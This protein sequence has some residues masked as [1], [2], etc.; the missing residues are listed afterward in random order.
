MEAFL[1]VVSECSRE[2]ARR[3]LEAADYNVERAVNFYFINQERGKAYASTSK[4]R[5]VVGEDEG[6]RVEGEDE[7]VRVEGVVGVEKKGEAKLTADPDLVL[8]P[9]KELSGESERLVSQLE[10]CP[11]E[12]TFLPSASWSRILSSCRAEGQSFTDP[13]FPPAAQSID[14]R[15]VHRNFG[16]N[17]KLLCL[18]KREAKL[19]KVAKDGKNQGKFFYACEL[20]KCKY[21][22]WSGRALQHTSQAVNLSWKRFDDPC[23]IPVAKGGFKPSDVLQGAVGDCWFLSGLAVIAERKDLV[24]RIFPVTQRN[25]EG[26]YECKFYID[27]QWESVVVDNVLPVDEERKPAFA[28]LSK[29]KSELWVPLLEKAYAKVHKSYDAISGGFVSEAMFDLTSYP[30]EVILVMDEA[31]ESEVTWA[32]LLSFASLKFPMGCSTQWDPT[33]QGVG[34]APCHAYSILEVIELSGVTVGQQLKIDD[35]FGGGKEREKAKKEEQGSLLRLLRIRNPHGQREWL[36]DWSDKSD[37]WTSTLHA[38]L[39]RTEK[40]D[41]TFWMSYQDFLCR[42]ALIEVCHAHRDFYNVTKRLRLGTPNSW[43]CAQF[44]VDLVEATWAYIMVLQKS[45]RGRLDNYWYTDVSIAIFRLDGQGGVVALEKVLFGG[46]NKTVFSELMMPQGQYLLN[47]FSMRKGVEADV[48]LRIFS[49][50][51]AVLTELGHGRDKLPPV[52]HHCM[53]QC[54]MNRACSSDMRGGVGGISKIAQHVVSP[55]LLLLVFCCSNTAVF[56]LACSSSE[57]RYS[58]LK[59]E[60]EAE[61]TRIKVD[62]A[63]AMIPPNA[64]KILAVLTPKKLGSH[65]FSYL[66]EE[67]GPTD[68]D[69]WMEAG[70][71]FGGIESIFKSFPL[72]VRAERDD[73][74][75]H[76]PRGSGAGVLL[77]KTKTFG[78]AQE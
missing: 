6:V 3:V 17:T 54:V 31:F 33:L 48:A 72:S 39:G 63:S 46:Q 35:F 37:K 60:V 2:E 1:S 65:K 66:W 57:K 56:F 45:K 49:A 13:D 53:I 32:R 64:Q 47:V 24:K 51:P 77:S 12:G 73:K 76:T 69:N 5:R 19:C 26:V 43:D 23:H 8:I 44:K 14:G 25:D 15:K 42:F 36:G 41:G 68:E 34:L 55:S 58:R 40:N 22:R 62:S 74:V 21:F 59:L 4:R 29:K 7:G 67:L 10:E 78:S 70:S 20:R 18:C 71:C 27:G 11:G 28:K 38:K 50:K 9:W 52:L 75:V 61:K 30:T 16:K